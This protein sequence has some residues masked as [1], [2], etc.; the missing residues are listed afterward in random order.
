MRK[1]FVGSCNEERNLIY[2]HHSSK[3]DFDEDAM[4]IGVE[5]LYLA[6][7]TFLA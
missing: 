1:F 2:P 5:I 3:F 6:T 7:E 4:E